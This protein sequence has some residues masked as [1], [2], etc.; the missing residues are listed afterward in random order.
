MANPLPPFHSPDTAP[1]IYFDVAPTFGTAAG[2]IQIELAS[3]TLVPT[4]DGKV[5]AELVVT[6][7]LRCSPTAIAD[8]R[9]AIDKA[10]EL[11]KQVQEQPSGGPS[12]AA[13]G[14]SIH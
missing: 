4:E 6:G 2:A 11:L 7:R 13:A 3:R 5:R 8:L 1:F 12:A 14:G 9:Q 10:L